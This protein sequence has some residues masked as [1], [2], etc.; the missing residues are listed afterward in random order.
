MEELGPVGFEFRGVLVERVDFEL[1][2]ARGMT[3]K[4]SRWTPRIS[5]AADARDPDRFLAFFD[6][7]AARKRNAAAAA[8]RAAMPTVIYAHGNASCRVEAITALPLVLSLGLSL[9]ALDTAGSGKSDG[10]FVSLGHFEQSD[11][12]AVANYLTATCGVDRIGLWGRSMGAA[13]CLLYAATMGPE[14]R[15][16]VADSSFGDL[17]GLCLD[18]AR[19]IAP[20]VPARIVDAAVERV[21]ASVK[22][23]ANFSVA[24]VSPAARVR[25]C[26]APCVLVHGAKDTFIPLAHAH[27]LYDAY[28]GRDV[29]LVMDSGG[30]ASARGKKANAAT[31][32]LFARTVA[33]GPPLFP[34]NP[35]YSGGAPWSHKWD[36]PRAS[37]S[38]ARA[39]GLPPKR[40]A[41]SA[42]RPSRLM[43][44]LGDLYDNNFDFGSGGPGPSARPPPPPPP[45]NAASPKAKARNA[46][47]ASGMSDERARAIQ[48]GEAIFRRKR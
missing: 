12:A 26:G 14:T 20:S 45:P 35:E 17:R 38:G 9:V 25:T 47:F 30:H 7:D 13:T 29:E 1:R 46:E 22:F 23:Y 41:Q 15:A 33:D 10:R 11:V 6:D 27:A 31:L 37:L 24:G 21:C 19:S 16:V 40:R 3:I 36:A 43:S 42:D 5:A 2:N 48:S 32:K 34:L 44:M 8:R 4:C 18:M 28:G 39:G